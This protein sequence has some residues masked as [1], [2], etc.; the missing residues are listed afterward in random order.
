[1]RRTSFETV[2]DVLRK[3]IDEA[4]LGNKLDELRAAE[5]WPGIIGPDLA[6]RCMKP[7]VNKGI[8]TIRV[9]DAALRN[10]LNMHRSAIMRTINTRLGRDV[11]SD[12]RFSG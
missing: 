9:N 2:G 6:S 7:C 10:E 12:L 4:N 11:L 8:M 5:I 3:I 1:M